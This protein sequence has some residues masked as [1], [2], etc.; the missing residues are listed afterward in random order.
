MRAKVPLRRAVVLLAVLS[1]CSQPAPTE[2][3]GVGV[4]SVTVLDEA[5]LPVVQATVTLLTVEM[6]SETNGYGTAWFADVPE[7]EHALVVVSMSV[8]SCYSTV[9]VAADDTTDHTVDVT[10]NRAPLTVYV[11]EAWSGLVVEGATVRII[12]DCDQAVVYQAVTDARG[13]VES[14]PL[15]A[16]SFTVRALEK[17][18]LL[19]ASEQVTVR[20]DQE[21]GVR[22]EM[23]LAYSE[24]SGAIDFDAG[25]HY[26]AGNPVGVLYAPYEGADFLIAVEPT[27]FV[28]TYN[29]TTE[30]KGFLVVAALGNE[31]P[32]EFAC[33]FS[34]IYDCRGGHMRIDVPTLY[35]GI[36]EA[37]PLDGVAYSDTPSIQLCCIRSTTDVSY[38]EWQVYHWTQDAS[39]VWQ[40]EL[41]WYTGTKNPTG[42]TYWDR[43]DMVHGMAP[44]STEGEVYSWIV[45]DL[46]YQD[47]RSRVTY[48][49]F[50]LLTGDE[51]PGMAPSRIAPGPLRT[52]AANSK[53]DR[54]S[55]VLWRL[56][57][58][59]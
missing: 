29:I 46:Y 27:T 16:R 11:A 4:L 57:G 44:W 47:G 9:T 7:G 51:T 28:S 31:T 36:E 43:R 30:Q 5:N 35:G 53:I 45:I 33:S 10:L 19:E 40:Y 24:L 59:R 55:S 54:T 18:P 1:A 14:L 20:S 17:Y 3:P 2:P 42:T 25:D 52:A 58:M 26:S 23:E 8:D 21:N 34:P 12:R 41:V 48:D 49:Y 39:G 50:F 38:C 37:Y 22:L 32:L 13:R 15:P 6:A 56:R